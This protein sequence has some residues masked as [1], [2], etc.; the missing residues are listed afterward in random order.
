MRTN[1][2]PYSD[3]SQL[4]Y[5][6]LKERIITRQIKPGE[7]I[8]QE[9]MAATLGVSRMPLQKAFFGRIS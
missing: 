6:R 4:P 5:E 2:L 1:P 3:L 8:I 9:K 7:K